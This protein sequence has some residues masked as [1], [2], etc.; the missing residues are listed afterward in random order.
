MVSTIGIVTGSL[1]GQAYNG[2]MVPLATGFF[3]STLMA[4]IVVLVTEKGRLFH[5]TKQPV[6]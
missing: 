4:F 5:A 3:V 6:Q 1:I 2:T